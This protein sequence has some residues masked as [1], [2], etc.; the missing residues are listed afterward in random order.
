V[1]VVEGSKEESKDGMDDE[2][3][4]VGLDGDV[5]RWDDRRKSLDG[6]EDAV[7]SKNAE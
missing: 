1:A 3:G 7:K 2:N 6:S 5:V 4:T